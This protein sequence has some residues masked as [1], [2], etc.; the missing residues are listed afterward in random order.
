MPDSARPGRA[1]TTR[2]AGPLDGASYSCATDDRSDS[3]VIRKSVVLALLIAYAAVM[4]LVWAW[5]L[6][7]DVSRGEAATVAGLCLLTIGFGSLILGGRLHSTHA[8][9]VMFGTIFACMLLASLGRP[10]R[11]LNDRGTPQVATRR[12]YLRT[13]WVFVGL[14]LPSV[15][16]I[17]LL[18][19]RL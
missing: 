5:R 14:L 15:G 12:E 17:I 2:R 11:M 6:T 10:A 8:A 13:Q 19:H 18:A 1:A 4:F 3:P 7:A 9:L 16:A